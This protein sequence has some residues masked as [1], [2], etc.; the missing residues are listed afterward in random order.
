MSGSGIVLRRIAIIGALVCW[1]S[2]SVAADPVRFSSDRVFIGTVTAET[3]EFGSWDRSGSHDTT[4]LGLLD[5]AL[6]D[7]VPDL[8]LA[9]LA[10][11]AAIQRSDVSATRWSG[12]GAAYTE[13]ITVDDRTHGSARA[14]S[15]MFIGFTLAE[16]MSYR[17]TGTATGEGGGYAAFRLDGPGGLGWIFQSG[18]A[19]PLV[20]MRRGLL[21]P[22]D[23]LFEA[24]AF[25]TA[26]S[27]RT[28]DSSVFE[29][30]FRLAD[31]VPE[32]ATLLLVGTGAAFV[33]R[34]AWRRRR[35]S[36]VVTAG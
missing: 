8:D 4:V 31:P 29:M 32:P 26:G 1:F 21:S 11:Y 16:P 33:G 25:S 27:G 17:F 36:G 34:T 15:L 20:A 22:G 35:K 7:F 10:S 3:A 30:E 13:G 19:V 12:S 18:N 2:S 14:E 24:R 9:R 5:F 28:T 6:T 23:Y